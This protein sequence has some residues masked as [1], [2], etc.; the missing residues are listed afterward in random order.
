MG[1]PGSLGK[2]YTILNMAEYKTRLGNN[3]AIVNYATLENSNQAVAVDITRVFNST[4]GAS[5]ITVDGGTKTGDKVGFYTYSNGQ[6]YDF[7]LSGTNMSTV[8]S[9]LSG[10]ISSGVWTD[11]R[12][13][14]QT[15]FR[16]GSTGQQVA[17]AQDFGDSMLMSTSKQ[18]VVGNKQLWTGGGSVFASVTGATGGGG[19]G[20]GGREASSSSRGASGGNGGKTP[21][22]TIVYPS[23]TETLPITSVSFSNGAKGNGGDN[24]HHGYYSGHNGV[25]GQNATNSTVSIAYAGEGTSYTKNLT[26]SGSGGGEGGTKGTSEGNGESGDQGTEVLTG[27]ITFSQTNISG[28]FQHNISGNRIDGGNG[29]GMSSRGGNGEDGQDGTNASHVVYHL[30][31]STGLHNR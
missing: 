16:V 25:N 28:G 2:F 21:V 27:E 17:Q 11:V 19:G 18:N 20:G 14:N 7:T 5:P 4:S 30:F 23:Q 24:G 12:A 10:G 8:L 29:G 6:S 3:S 15:G 1:D 22:R 26:I 9:G 31:G 13:S